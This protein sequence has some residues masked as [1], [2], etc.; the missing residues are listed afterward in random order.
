MAITVARADAEILTILFPMRIADS[1]LLLFSRILSTS[2]AFLFPSSA[3]DLI[4]ILFTVVRAVSADEKNADNRIKII[5]TINLS[6]VSMSNK[7][8]L[9][10][11]YSI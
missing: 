10:W 11:H 2:A 7:N 1:I 6:I 9:L 8:A 4:L 5:N 3:R